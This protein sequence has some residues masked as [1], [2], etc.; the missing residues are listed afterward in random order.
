MHKKIGLI[1]MLLLSLAPAE[2]ARRPKRFAIIFNMGY[3]KD[4]LPKD[5]QSF[6]RLIQGIKRAHF[7]TVLCRYTPWRAAIC[8]KHGVQIF[9]DLLA[10]E[11]HV[12]KNPDGAQQLCESLRDNPVVYGYHLWSDN[13]GDT[14]PGRSRDVKNVHAWDPTHPAYVGTYRMNRVN[15][16]AGLDLLGYYDFH[17]KRGGHWGHVSKA[18]TVAKGKNALFLRYCD[19]A[20]GRIGAGNPNRAGYTIATSIPFGLKGYLFHYGG[21]VVD[22]KTGQLDALGRDLQKV[23]GKFAA[24][25][26]ALM[27]IG[28]PRAVYS[29]PISRT[30]KDRPVD[31]APAVPGGLAPVPE[32][33]WFQVVRGEVLFGMFQDD[34][35]RDVVVFA[36]HNAYAPQAVT[37]EFTRPL[38]SV[39]FFNRKT[40]R[41]IRLRVARHKASFPVE[42]FAGELIRIERESIQ[43]LEKGRKRP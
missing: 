25:G 14:Y 26:D 30:A 19:A 38:K 3:A 24:M 7:N 39:S 41:W 15:R 22:P 10:A 32:D 43:R 37:L 35:Q 1:M 34:R 42:E 4:S 36:G 31:G 28:N 12:Y 27:A 23:N 6:A 17:W 18:S 33:H 5:P 11:H 40:G 13:I 8:K 16:V 2:E 21:G 20:P 9:V 29:T